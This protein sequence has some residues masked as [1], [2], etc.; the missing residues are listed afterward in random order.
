MVSM[1]INSKILVTARQIMILCRFRVQYSLVQLLFTIS[2]SND[3]DLYLLYD[4]G[5]DVLLLLQIYK[6]TTSR[7]TLMH[8]L[9]TKPY[10]KGCCGS[11]RSLHKL[12]LNLTLN[13]NTPS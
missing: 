7:K 8:Q 11:I 10:K 12:E 6:R 9:N 3:D 13:R 1:K 2:C 4:S 5:Y